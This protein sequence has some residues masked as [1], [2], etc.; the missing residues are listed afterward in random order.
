MRVGVNFWH[1][2]WLGAEAP[3]GDPARLA[4]ELDQLAEAGVSCVRVMA[5]AEGPHDAEERVVPA[6][7]P[8]PG[9]WDAWLLRG[10]D[11]ALEAI[12]ARG[13]TAIVCLGNFW[14]W[15]GGLA[16]YRA[17]ASGDAMPAP[18]SSGFEAYSAGFYRDRGARA[19]F[20]AHVDVVLGR[21]AGHAAIEAWEV[22]NEPRGKHDPE[23]MRAF[24]VETAE[25]IRRFDPG[26][27]VASGTEGS[28]QSPESAGLDFRSDHK[29]PAIDVTTC[30]L[31]PQNWGLWDPERDDDAQF[32][33]VLAWSRAYL[34]RH[35]REA[36]ELDKPLWIEELGLARDGG[37]F[38]PEATTTRRDRFFDAMLETARALESEGLP[39]AGLL[40]WAW[41]GEGGERRGDPPH[42]PAGWY[43]IRSGDASTLAVL[44]RH[45]RR[46][47]R[48]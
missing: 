14:W 40:A 32:D 44:G 31:W 19:L 42:E 26:A 17:W 10:L 4:R 34:E 2:M 27:R 35:A 16:Q 6:L 29:D 41:T 18:G 37:R 39:V 30:H 43:G 24:L 3:V 47:N 25:R 45:A 1:V 46:A 9:V 20:D 5:G 12:A 36:A 23:G 8:E 22:C 13:M 38:D 33:D 7:Q 15:S 28:T 48:G 11:A 21:L